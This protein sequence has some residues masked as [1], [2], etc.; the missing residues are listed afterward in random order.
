M[1]T[2]NADSIRDYQ[3]CSFYYQQ[4]YLSDSQIGVFAREQLADKFEQT[5]KRVVSFFFYKRQGGIVPSY[6]ALLNRWEKLWFP[7]GT[8]S[9]DISIEIHE[10]A[11]K[12]LASYSNTAAAALLQFYKDF[13]DYQ[14]DPIMIDEK[15]LIPIN[16]EMRLEGVFD[17][18]LRKR[19]TFQVIRWSAKTK[20]PPVE[21]L[22]YDFAA[23]KL[24]Y[25]YRNETKR[26]TE[27]LFYDLGSSHPGGVSMQPIDD[28]VKA[29]LFWAHEA[30]KT[31]NYVP[32]R[33]FTTYCRGCAYDRACRNFSFS[34]NI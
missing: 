23:Q 9:Y 30:Q 21:S 27:Y 11:H 34:G 29:L 13:I 1:L 8:T 22:T 15:F 16:E 7:K 24:A 4:K 31:E 25:E 12:N 3:V 5:L 26:P 17:L 18:V 33:G 28:D 2:V 10:S 32:R 20:R 19:K 14:G 6:N